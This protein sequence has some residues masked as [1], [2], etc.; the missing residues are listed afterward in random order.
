[1]VIAANHPNSLLPLRWEIPPS[2]PLP[3]TPSCWQ[4]HLYDF[5][6]RGLD[7]EL[8][9]CFPRFDSNQ[10]DFQTWLTAGALLPAKSRKGLQWSKLTCMK[11]P[12]ETLFCTINFLQIYFFQ[13]IFHKQDECWYPWQEKEQGCLCRTTATETSIILNWSWNHIL[14]LKETSSVHLNGV[15]CFGF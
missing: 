7:W 1:M 9:F 14:T 3:H 15:G 2:S 12:S 4:K 6:D 11:V 10:T 5:S 8:V 13:L